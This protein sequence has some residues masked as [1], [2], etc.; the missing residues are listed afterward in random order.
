[1][2]TLEPKWNGGFLLFLMIALLRDSKVVYQNRS[3]M[4]S[5]CSLLSQPLKPHLCNR[6]DY[7]RKNFKKG[8][9]SFHKKRKQRKS[10]TY[11]AGLGLWCINK[12]ILHLITSGQSQINFYL[13]SSTTGF[14]SSIKKSREPKNQHP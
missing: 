5:M 8:E 2:N 4:S 3:Q 14:P 9:L 12:T 6:E 1:M 7:L 10:S 13:T 11:S